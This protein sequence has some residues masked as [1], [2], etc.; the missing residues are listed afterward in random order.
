MLRS[1]LEQDALAARIA[2]L[3]RELEEER[4]EHDSNWEKLNNV[5]DAHEALMNAYTRETGKNL[6]TEKEQDKVEGSK[7]AEEGAATTADSAASADGF[8]LV[9]AAKSPAV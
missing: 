9:D 4:A 2:S 1:L 8:D 6:T 5:T 7:S 3:T